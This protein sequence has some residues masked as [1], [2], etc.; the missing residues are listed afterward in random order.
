MSEVQSKAYTK[1]ISETIEIIDDHLED[2]AHDHG[3]DFPLMEN[4]LNTLKEAVGESS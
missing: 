2:V 4:L 1:L 3:L